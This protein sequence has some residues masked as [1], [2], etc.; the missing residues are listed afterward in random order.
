V[1]IHQ[2]YFLQRADGLI[3]IG[4]TTDFAGRLSALTTSHGM[5]GI[6][7]VIH[8]GRKREGELHHR[9]RHFHEYG[10]WFRPENGKLEALISGLEEGQEIAVGQSEA[11]TEWEAGEAELMDSVRSKIDLMIK[12]RMDRT[13]LK[14]D[15]ALAALSAEHGFSPWFLWHTRK[16]ASTVSAYAY[17]RISAA[18]LSEMRELL[19]QLNSEIANLQGDDGAADALRALA[20]KI[21]TRK[22]ALK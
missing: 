16:R 2:I 10:E 1:S 17:Q 3:K 11:R 8:G 5:L 21:E 6:V 12:A 22:A 14:R 19:A 4:T 15:A 13:L 9:F 18:Y 7:R 20:A